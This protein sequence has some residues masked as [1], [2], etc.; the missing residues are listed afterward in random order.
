MARSTGGGGAP[1]CGA[2]A[3]MRRRRE[4]FERMRES[5]PAP[6]WVPAGVLPTTQD[7]EQAVKIGPA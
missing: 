1:G 5:Y 2:S 3:V 6:W 7:A 4:W